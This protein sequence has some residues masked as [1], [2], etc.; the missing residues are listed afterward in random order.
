M[1]TRNIVPRANGEGSIGTAVKHWGN[2][3][4]DELNTEKLVADDVTMVFNSVADMKNSTELKAGMSAR[5]LG[6]YAVN[7]GGGAMYAVRAANNDT[8]NGGSVI[9]LE[10]G[11]VA[12]LVVIN[13]AVSPQQFGAKG[14]GV[15]IDNVA[16]NNCFAFAATKKYKVVA[17]ANKTY[18]VDGSTNTIDGHKGVLI[19]A[20]LCVEGMNFKLA[21]N[22]TDLSCILTCKYGPEEYVI[23]NC[24]FDMG[25]C[26]TV[27][28]REDGGCHGIL[29][30]NDTTFPTTWESSGNITVINC[31]FK[32]IW[33]YGIFVV[34]FDGTIY[35]NNCEFID[36]YAIGVLTYATNSIV[37]HCTYKYKTNERGGIPTLAHDEIENFNAASSIKKNVKISNCTSNKSIYRIMSI[38]YNVEYGDVI[39]INCTSQSSGAIQVNSVDG[40]YNTFDC[41]KINN[42]KLNELWLQAPTSNVYI[43]DSIITGEIIGEMKELHLAH[44]NFNCIRSKV[45]DLIK[46]DDVICS[47]TFDDYWAIST[48]GLSYTESDIGIAKIIAN[49]VLVA[50]KG[51][52]RACRFGSC[53]IDGIKASGQR[54][55]FILNNREYYADSMNRSSVF[56][57]NVFTDVVMP[58]DDYTMM[59]AKNCVITGISIPGGINT[60]ACTN[61]NIDTKWTS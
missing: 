59:Y 45:S 1:A 9:V 26:N 34:P 3:Y 21:D 41:F 50:K 55:L 22:V 14:D 7:D 13:N 20:P 10:N 25:I 6:Y 2:G 40:H 57:M 60:Y 31:K 35:V 39:I 29:F 48:Y 8:D 23:K 32:N 38:H 17:N 36:M 19:P 49:N 43:N 18:I 37:S 5:T 51:F 11:N 54:A 47:S 42:C 27:N 4:F 56:A 61:K 12:E 28:G 24:T 30:I 44:T 46:L 52:I 58:E 53:I 15:T 16:L 33:S